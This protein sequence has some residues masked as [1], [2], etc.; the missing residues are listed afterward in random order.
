MLHGKMISLSSLSL[1]LL[2]LLGSVYLINIQY[3]A[4]A[5]IPPSGGSSPTLYT[6]PSSTDGNNATAERWPN[7]SLNIPFWVGNY[8]RL[9]EPSCA[10]PN[11]TSTCTSR[12]FESFSVGINQDGDLLASKFPEQADCACSCPV[13]FGTDL[14]SIASFLTPTEPLLLLSYNLTYI[15]ASLSGRFYTLDQG[16]CDVTYTKTNST[17]AEVASTPKTPF[18][19]RMAIG[20][21]KSKRAFECGGEYIEQ[22]A[23][24]CA[25]D[26]NDAIYIDFPSPTGC[27]CPERS[28]ASL[29]SGPP[30]TLQFYPVGQL[31][32]NGTA[33]GGENSFQTIVDF[34]MSGPGDPF[35]SFYFPN[36]AF[37]GGIYTSPFAATT[38]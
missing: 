4:S 27:I 10:R 7:G 24:I 15:E 38:P 36:S 3:G 31:A 12:C 8:S 33:I 6:P 13:N 22:S 9:T 32:V 14:A 23:L 2:H 37:C 30:I 19:L 17:A 28:V 29:I 26:S 25:I 18:W 35:T 11:M 21:Y 16:P 1:L 34:S 5:G 20:F